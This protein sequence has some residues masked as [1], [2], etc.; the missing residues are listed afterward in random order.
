[1]ISGIQSFPLHFDQSRFE[2]GHNKKPNGTSTQWK[3]PILEYSSG[4]FEIRRAMIRSFLNIC[5]ALHKIPIG[6]T[7]L[8][9]RTVE[10]E[11]GTC[12]MPSIQRACLQTHTHILR[13]FR[14]CSQPHAERNKIAWLERERNEVCHFYGL[15]RHDVHVHYGDRR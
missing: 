10:N 4:F 8:A 14:I 3:L 9:I 12:N 11:P 13:H 2:I 7:K 15:E 6:S 5:G 1:M